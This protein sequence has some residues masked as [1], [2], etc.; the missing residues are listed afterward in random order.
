M[1]RYITRDKVFSFINL[2]GLAVGFTAVAYIGNFIA[3]ETGYDN[4]HVNG[5]HIYRVSVNDRNDESFGEAYTIIPAIG[6]AAKAQIPEVVEYARVSVP[7]SYFISWG[8]KSL[9]TENV[10]FADTAFFDLFSFPLLKGDKS[11]VLSAPYTVALSAQTA[12]RL[13]GDVEPVGKTVR[14]NGADYTVTGVAAEPPLNSDLRFSALASFATLYRMPDRSMGWNGGN[15]YM[16][17]LH[18]NP[19]AE[20]P[21]VVQKLNGLLRERLK[22]DYTALD[23]YLRPLQ[24]L[25][26]RYSYESPYLRLALLVLSAVALLTVVVAVINFVNL[27]TARSLKR[28]K[29]AGVRKALGA[30]RGDLVQLFLGESLCVSMVAFVCTCLLFKLLEPVYVS[31]TNSPVAYDGRTGFVFLC[32]GGLAVV[33]G[34]LG[35]SYP[36]LRLSSL[37]M[38]EVSKGGGERKR[39][40]HQVQNVL[41]VVQL[42][43]SSVLIVATGVVYRQLAYVQQKDI[44]FRK[45]GIITIPLTGKDERA[46]AAAL[47]EQLSSTTGVMASS[48]S[49]D[50]P[51]GNFT[52]NGYLLPKAT[53]FSLIH[54]VDVDGDFPEVYGIRLKTGRFFPKDN[55]AATSAY[56]INE[57]LAQQIGGVDAAL[58]QTI[59]RNGA[60]EIIGVVDDFHY[61][62]LYNDIEPLIMT[63]RPEAGAFTKVSIKYSSPSVG[64]VLQRIEEV[65][66][67]VNPDSPFEYVFFDDLYK[68]QYELEGYFGRLF[69]CFAVIAIVLAALGMLNLMAY[70]TEQR[71]KEIGIRK[72]VGAS[73]QDILALLLWKTGRQLIV[74]NLI[75]WPVAW[76]V[77]QQWLNHFA[78]RVPV[79]WMVFAVSLLASV[80]ITLL[81]V[82]FQAY[83]AATANPVEA[84]K[85]NG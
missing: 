53:Q 51:C 65:W 78:Y 54:V 24:E 17:Y 48:S 31:L 57:R 82:G 80:A 79:G 41:V 16:T 9:K 28:I 13:F 12:D 5:K 4:F 3:Q 63:N 76:Y 18:V 55:H 49:S 25:H 33:T 45:E 40:K 37:P 19:R 74:A 70:T 64:D 77:A 50:V 27:T 2:F 6:P 26:L 59:Q 21:V 36:A 85:V 30:R 72:V 38:S 29:E 8:E 75:A 43:I 62:S 68:S 52:R 39:K 7:Y 32:I 67:R 46:N 61:A 56:V 22:D 1:L 71:K 73:V 44:G 14:I 69:F 34:V 47:K 83:R 84:I 10:V 23:A 11:A 15:Q 66:H 58:G 81:S 42:A 20:M 60:H 35:G